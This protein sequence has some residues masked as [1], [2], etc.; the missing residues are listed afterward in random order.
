MLTPPEEPVSLPLSIRKLLLLQSLTLLI[1][2]K[3][4]VC[5]QY[6]ANTLMWWRLLSRYPLNRTV[7]SSAKTVVSPSSVN[8]HTATSKGKNPVKVEL[9]YIYILIHRQRRCKTDYHLSTYIN[10]TLR[11][12]RCKNK[13]QINELE[14]NSTMLLLKKW[15]TNTCSK[16]ND[17]WRTF[18]VQQ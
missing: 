13:R 14:E 6:S 7:F 18:T 3:Y 12:Q 11:W 8:L 17:S 9:L 16:K 1:Y 4:S 2:L 10:M 5:K 15:I